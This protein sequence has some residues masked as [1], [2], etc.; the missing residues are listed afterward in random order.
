MG[1]LLTFISPLTEIIQSLFVSET[2][3]LGQAGYICGGMESMYL[4]K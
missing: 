4:F 2:C 3:S 1:V